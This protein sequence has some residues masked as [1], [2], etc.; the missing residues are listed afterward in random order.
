MLIDVFLIF[1]G[2]E[3]MDSMNVI[4]WM[5]GFI[6][7]VFYGVRFDLD[8]HVVELGMVIIMLTPVA[9]VHPLS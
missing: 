1:N 4:L 7:K 5:T 2:S 8:V 3:D 9:V 6:I